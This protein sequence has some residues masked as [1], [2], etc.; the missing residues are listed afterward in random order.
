M[1]GYAKTQRGVLGRSGF[2]DGTSHR[3]PKHEGMVCHSAIERWLAKSGQGFG[4][5]RS[6][7][8]GGKKLSDWLGMMGISEANRK[9]KG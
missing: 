3:L 1:G 2:R 6:Q 7:A 8:R 5:H 9:L 4:P